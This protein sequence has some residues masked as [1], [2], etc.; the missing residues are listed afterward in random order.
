M[1]ISQKHPLIYTEFV[2]KKDALAVRFMVNGSKEIP[3]PENG[4]LW[5]TFLKTNRE[6]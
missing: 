5:D 1:V 6:T 4:M 3:D 2:I